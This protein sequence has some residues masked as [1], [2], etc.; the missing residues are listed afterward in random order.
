MKNL[1]LL[2]LFVSTQ[3]AVFAQKM[4]LLERRNSPKTTRYYLGSTL[5][6]QYRSDKMWYPGQ[7]S[8]IQVDRQVLLMDQLLV[9]IDSIGAL[10]MPKSP[11]TRIGGGA[12][13]TFGASL[14]FASTI[15]LLYGDK[16]YNY[17]LLYGGALASGG[18]GMALMRPKSVKL[19]GKRRLRG[20][21]VAFGP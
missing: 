15:A 16:G 6:Y 19:G 10:R 17:P 12:L 4:L 21:E 7:L 9:P 2:A 5:N 11:L 8:D 13:F 14:T 18:I 3:S 1:M 20:I